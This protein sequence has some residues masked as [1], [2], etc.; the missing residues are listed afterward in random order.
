MLLVFNGEKLQHKFWYLINPIH[1][2]F[3]IPIFVFQDGIIHLYSI[4]GNTLKDEG[5]TVEVNKTRIMDMAFSNDGAYLVVID[6]SKVAT[7]LTVAEGY[8][9]NTSVL[10]TTCIQVG[11]DTASITAL[12]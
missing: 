9:V 8:S 3:I 1:V 10:H 4:E 7:V 6:E 5:Q 2:R 11:Q 12:Y